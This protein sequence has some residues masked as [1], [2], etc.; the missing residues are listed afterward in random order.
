MEF[1]DEIDLH[2]TGWILQRIGWALVLLIMITALLGVYGSGWLSKETTSDNGYSLSYEK[3]GRFE[4]PTTITLD[5][6]SS[7]KK[8][9]VVN[10]PS[11][12]TE[13]Q[14]I[15]NIIPQPKEQKS[16]NGLTTFHFDAADNAK[17]VFYLEPDAIGSIK[18]SFTVNGTV[19]PISHFIYP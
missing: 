18:G 9:I 4:T 6:G 11:A 1:E 5:V 12:Y 17:I 2:K 10:I 13:K 7:G 8:E 3:Y 14:E 19:L 15:S 16:A